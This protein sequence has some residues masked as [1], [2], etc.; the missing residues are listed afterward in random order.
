[1]NEII[2]NKACDFVIFGI[3]GDLSKRKLL[4]SLYYLEK[5][6]YIHNDTNIIG[7]SRSEFNIKDNINMIKKSLLNFLKEKIN[8]EI[9]LKF[10]KRFKFCN[11]DVY[12]S[13]NFIKL[14][15]NINLKNKII[16]YYFATPPNTFSYI[17]EGLGK[18]K[19]NNNNT[20][21][22]VEKP[23]G[24]NLKSYNYINK[25][26][27]K[28]FKEIQVYRIDHYLGKEII[29]NLLALRFSN[30]LFFSN[31]NN[32]IIDSVQIT[33]FEQ[34][35]IEGRSEYFNKIGQT[36]D[37]IQN[38]LL[39]ILT[40][41]TMAPPLSLN[42]NNI[43]E[44]KIK[45]LKSL[46]RIDYKNINENTVIGQYKSG[47]I[48][49]NKVNSYLEEKGINNKSNTETFVAIKANIDNWQW[50]GVPFYLRT[51]KRLKK[52]IAEIVIYFK[53]LPINLFQKFNKNLLQNKLIIRLYPNEGIEIKILNKL[54]GLN[55][56]YKLRKTK[57]NFNFYGKKNIHKPDA[58]ELLILEAMLGNQSLFV[59]CNEIKES[60]K[61][62]D[63]IINGWKKKKIKPIIYKSG[64][65]GPKES[66]IL[67][68]KDGRKWN[69][70]L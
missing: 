52:K 2:K 11:L 69:K 27:L 38:H 42:I 65:W 49:N 32:S 20:R 67:I 48:N 10:S 43:N 54:Y 33:I 45:I 59:S 3:N 31:W 50:L 56:N 14:K 70:Y 30:I 26:I 1:M 41:I 46:R 6:K 51:G 5:F 39:Q 62:I 8:N 13:D 40:I 18:N 63:L 35:G 9:W 19:I 12:Y 4:P 61:W 7:V 17:C 55:N 66:D 29:L 21:I 34:I 37:M 60:W 44:E 24:K 53:N 68:E 25:I 58:Y 23:L 57:L 64:T 16:I 28:Y 36:R 15:K 22:I 47:I